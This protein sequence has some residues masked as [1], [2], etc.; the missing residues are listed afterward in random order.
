MTEATIKEK[1]Q[2]R[3]CRQCKCKDGLIRKYNLYLCRKCFKES[4][5]KLGF[6]KY[7]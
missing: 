7:E 3:M 1:K 2:A 6:R 5:E 4:A